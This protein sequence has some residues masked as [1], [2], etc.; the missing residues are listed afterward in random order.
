MSNA[1]PSN[2]WRVTGK[3][4]DRVALLVKGQLKVDVVVVLGVGVLLHIA[5]ATHHAA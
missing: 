3:H 5:P 1:L 2:I 4:V